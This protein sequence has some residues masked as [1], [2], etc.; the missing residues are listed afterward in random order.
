MRCSFLL[1]QHHYLP[2]FAFSFFFFFLPDVLFDT[3]CQLYFMQWSLPS[4]G[5]IMHLILSLC[6]RSS[7][8]SVDIFD[9]AIN[10]L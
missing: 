8:L 10:H 2:A 6:D 5:H 9:L 4:H 1:S 3:G 7:V